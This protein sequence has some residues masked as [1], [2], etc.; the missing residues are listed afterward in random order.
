MKYKG[1]VGIDVS[2]NTLDAVC[3]EKG[4]RKGVHLIISN[5]TKGF[6]ELFK[7]LNKTLKYK[8][9]EILFCMEHTGIYTY[10]IASFLSE[11]E[12]D[13]SLENPL[14]IKRSMGI[15]RI[16]NDK[17][18]A[19]LIAKYAMRHLDSLKLYKLPLKAI[20]KLKHLI[21]YRE[22]LIKSKR[23]MKVASNELVK[24]VEKENSSFISKETNS[25]LKVLE[26]KIKNVDIEI[27]DT[28]N[29]VKELKT[30]YDL[31]LSVG[32]VGPAVAMNVIAY[33]NNFTSF[34]NARQFACYSGIAPFEHTSGISLKGKTRISNLANKKMKSLIGIGACSAIQHDPELK[35][36]Y[37]RRI[38]EGKN[39]LSTI[40]VIRNKIVSRMFAVVKRGTPFV[41]MTTHY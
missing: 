5:D 39:P 11:K 20:D 34:Q 30:N 26:S 35:K 14:Q 13:F 41:K 33:T 40:N 4:K 16:K 7:W 10:K 17:A 22:R 23:A 15:T 21:A 19:L 38:D 6:K 3:V 9:K 18:D 2:K 1:Y 37:H 25:L 24:C 27:M 28:I 31:I 36:Y 8:S 32:G 12:L 29:S